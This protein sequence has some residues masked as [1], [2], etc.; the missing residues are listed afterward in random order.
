MRRIGFLLQKEFLQIFRTRSMV[1]IIFVMPVI[2]LLILSNA[3]T[4][5]IK[6]IKLHVIDLDQ[7]AQSY[8]HHEF[9]FAGTDRRYA[10][11]ADF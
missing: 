10:D 8:F 9:L 4:Y 11:R 2:Q 6:N 5:E 7:S 3:V 1:M